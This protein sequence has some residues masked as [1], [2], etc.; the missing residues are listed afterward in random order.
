MRPANLKSPDDA[1]PVASSREAETTWHDPMTHYVGSPLPA[2]EVGARSPRGAVL[3]EA[4]CPPCRVAAETMN[5][6]DNMERH[7]ISCYSLEHGERHRVA[8]DRRG[9]EAPRGY[10]AN[11]LPVY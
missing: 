4:P 5:M 7:E 3:A 6:Q 11:A 1:G 10:A 2:R 8:V 9:G